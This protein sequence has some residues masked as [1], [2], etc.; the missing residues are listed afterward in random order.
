MGVK[1]GRREAEHSPPSSAHVKNACRYTSTFSYVFLTWC[2]IKWDL[3]IGEYILRFITVMNC[4]VSLQACSF[5]ERNFPSYLPVSC[6][7]MFHNYLSCVVLFFPQKMS[8]PFVF[9][10]C[11]I[12]SNLKILSWV[13]IVLADYIHDSR[14][15]V[16]ML[17]TEVSLLLFQSSPIVSLSRREALRVT[18]RF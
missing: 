6:R 9:Y 11:V 15:C 14:G 4:K 8:I 5:S 12:S 16:H 18:C 17:G 2:L 7:L 3:K 1:A 13:F 10:P